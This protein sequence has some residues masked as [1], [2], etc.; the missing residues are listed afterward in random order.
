KRQRPP[1][2]EML[3]LLIKVGEAVDYAHRLGLLHLDLKPAN[4]LIDARGEPLVADFGLARHMDAEGAVKAQEVSGTPAYMAPEQILIEQYRLTVATD[5]Y[6]LGALLYRCLSGV[7]PHG[8]GA[9]ADLIRRALAGQIRP[10]SEVAPGVDRDLAAVCTKC[11]A[12]DQRGQV[13]DQLHLKADAPRR[14][15]R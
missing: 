4:I 7:S 12:L 6:A 15:H 8:E 2:A 14:G 3:P 10:L 5:I 9:A 1:R 11:L 13:G